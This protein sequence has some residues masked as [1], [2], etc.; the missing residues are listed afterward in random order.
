ML[1]GIGVFGTGNFKLYVVFN[2]IFNLKFNEKNY[3]FIKR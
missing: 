1:P 2:I 3:D